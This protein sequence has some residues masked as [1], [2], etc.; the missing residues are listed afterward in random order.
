MVTHARRAVPWSLV[1]ITSVLVVVMLAIVGR[2][3]W[4]MWPLQGVAVGLLAG[5][6]A[7]CLDDPSP[8]IADT[9]ARHLRW[10][11]A[12]QGLGVVVLLAA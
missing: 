3:P 7:W 4:D 8:E 6:A 12:A 9:T 1:A 2:R 10:R 5:T 11:A